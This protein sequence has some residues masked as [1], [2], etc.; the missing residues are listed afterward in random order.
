MSVY[1][2]SLPIFEPGTCQIHVYT[3]TPTQSCTNPSCN[4]TTPT[5][6]EKNKTAEG[7]VQKPVYKY[8][9]NYLITSVQQQPHVAT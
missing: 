4:D 1:M 9:T 8:V 5:T 3:A 6:A 2:T 7:N